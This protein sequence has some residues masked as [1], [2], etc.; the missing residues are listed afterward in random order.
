M[1]ATS[2]FPYIAV[3]L[4]DYET[5]AFAVNV[6]AKYKPVDDE[7]TY[8]DINDVQQI[9][10][11]YKGIWKSEI[12][13]WE[14]GC[15]TLASIDW[16][17]V[18][19]GEA[20][21]GAQNTTAVPAQP[22]NT[23]SRPVTVASAATAGSTAVVAGSGNNDLTITQVA[24]SACTT[25]VPFQAAPAPITPEQRFSE[26]RLRT[27]HRRHRICPNCCSETCN[28]NRHTAG[29]CECG[30]CE[31]DGED[32][33]FYKYYEEY[34]QGNNTIGSPNSSASSSSDSTASAETNA[35]KE[36]VATVMVPGHRARVVQC[37]YM[38]AF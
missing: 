38:E 27:K 4:I 16:P 7:G 20:I 11:V 36:T 34:Q 9:C 8:W 24:S 22:S 1:K 26:Y 14:R 19:L 15:K 10:L 30:D 2:V 5:L 21:G 13:D 35:S 3:E 37:I 33:E 31:E 12:E 17:K 28:L 18:A 32:D 25:A 6:E 23:S 29:E